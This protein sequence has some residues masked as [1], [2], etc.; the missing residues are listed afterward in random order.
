MRCCLTTALFALALSAPVTAL[1]QDQNGCPPGA[2]FCEETEVQ[3]PPEI[4]PAE[5]PAAQP[6]PAA[7]PALPPPQRGTTVVIPPP[8]PGRAA[9]PPVVVYQPVPSTPPPQVV[10]I[11]PGYYPA[12]P[13]PVRAVP[14]P[15]KKTKKVRTWRREFGLN[16]RLQGVALGSEESG[17]SEEAGMGGIGMSLRFRPVPAFAIDAGVDLMAGIDYNGFDRTEIPLSLN[18]ILYVNP[19]SRVQFYF[20]GGADW[21]HAEVESDVESPLLEDGY[22]GE[23]SYF[24]GHGGIGLEFRVARHVGINIDGLAFV[25]GRTDDGRLPEFMDENGRTTNTSGG[26][27]FRAGVTFWW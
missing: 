25:R 1:A 8:P 19:K 22:S 11:A 10:I 7:R 5:P 26:G 21:S 18:G 4:A 12:A 9:P 23:Y 14:P 16:L 3:P 2:W 27:L 17:A 15:A 13:G 6:R 24:G 20:I